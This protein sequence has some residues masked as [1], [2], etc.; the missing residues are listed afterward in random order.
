MEFLGREAELAALEA[1]YASAQSAFFPIYGR[2]RV[3]KTELILRFMRGRPGLYF[4]GKQAPAAEQIRE[5][6]ENAALAFGEPLLAELQVDNWKKALTQALARRP[7]DRKCVLVI[8]EFQWAAAAAPGL[9]SVLQELWDLDWSR[10][11]NIF[12]ILCG[13]YLGFM[14]REVLGRKSPLFGRR[15]GQ[16]LLEPFGYEEAARFHPGLRPVDLAR[17][18]FFC[19]GIPFY[20]KLFNARQSLAVNLQTNFLSPFGP[21]HREAEF[22]LR[23]ELREVERYQAVLMSLATGSLRAVDIARKSGIPSANLQYYLKHLLELGYLKRRLPLSSRSAGA[24]AVRYAVADPVLRFW[25][26]FIF[27]HA[28]RIVSLGPAAAYDQLISPELEAYC[29]QCFEGLCRQA[30]PRLYRREPVHGAFEIGEYWDSRVQIDVVGLRDDGR[31][32]LGEC[33][34]GPV[35]SWSGLVQELGRRIA[36]YPNPENRTVQGWLFTRQ[37]GSRRDPR[38]RYVCLEDLYPAEIGCGS[39]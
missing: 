9:T 24:H 2:R 27:P 3:G 17:T 31:I 39:E 15:T 33:R 4:L 30:L 19:G 11:G 1:A 20:L 10:A 35:G 5:F 14:E 32:D 7:R 26:R 6:L 28:S 37:R 13:S 29:G 16:I 25:F 18:W 38:T 22:L 34:W 21:L 23:E 8:D 36:A 12:L